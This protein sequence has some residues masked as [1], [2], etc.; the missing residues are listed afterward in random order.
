MTFIFNIFKNNILCSYSSDCLGLQ[1]VTLGQVTFKK[2]KNL[3]LKKYLQKFLKLFLN[4]KMYLIS[5]WLIFIKLH[6]VTEDSCISETYKL[7]EQSKNNYVP[8]NEDAYSLLYMIIKIFVS[9]LKYNFFHI[10]T[11]C[12][13][14]KA[15]LTKM[16]LSI[17]GPK[18][19]RV[20]KPLIKYCS[21]LH[22]IFP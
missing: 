2:L 4:I 10:A 5:M 18:Y 13:Q 19:T 11:V 16:M 8:G 17:I 22:N 1:Y 21:I 14:V 6:I 15:Q 20:T 3:N 9:C 7:N 12:V